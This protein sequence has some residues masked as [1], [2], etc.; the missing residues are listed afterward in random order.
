MTLR[1]HGCKEEEQ[2]IEVD[3]EETERPRC[4]G[5]RHVDIAVTQIMTETRMERRMVIRRRSF[6]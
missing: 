4:L 2:A 6:K 5:P 1:V 3:V